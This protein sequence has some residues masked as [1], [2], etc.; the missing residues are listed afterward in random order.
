MRSES[1][2]RVA[3]TYKEN[4]LAGPPW[5]F[6]QAGV[7]I[8]GLVS[9]HLLYIVVFAVLAIPTALFV[10]WA[11]RLVSERSRLSVIPVVAVVAVVLVA[12]VG[13]TTIRRTYG[14]R[15]LRSLAGSDSR[16]ARAAEDVLTSEAVESVVLIDPETVFPTGSLYR[17][18]ALS[19]AQ[20]ADVQSFIREALPEDLVLDFAARDAVTVGGGTSIGGVFVLAMS[21]RVAQDPE[22]M[23][24]LVSRAA[25]FRIERSLGE[26]PLLGRRTFEF[27]IGE[28]TDNVPA[29]VWWRR[30]TNLVYIVVGLTHT[31]CR[32]I[33][34][35]IMEAEAR[36]G[37]VRVNLDEAFEDTAAYRF[38]R[39]PKTLEESFTKG[40]ERQTADFFEGLSAWFVRS[41]GSAFAPP[42][43][44]VIA[45][46]LIPDRAATPGFVPALAKE[47]GRQSHTSLQRVTIEGRITYQFSL[48]KIDFS[49]FAAMWR[50]P[51][52]TLHVLVVTEK[53]SELE[54]VAA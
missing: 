33:A 6:G 53:A 22:F 11:V 28:H 31:G 48:D 9:E 52:T 26:R 36:S 49:G 21:R 44:A 50:R 42:V 30:G 3:K 1:A 29:V 39:V 7:S 38:E 16:P 14:V 23:E 10:M 19:G 13:S 25:R 18:E 24:D 17:Y 2:V 37:A 15:P 5:L 4:K 32:E 20:S 43:G 47:L 27:M 8:P 34:R 54:K 12:A 40:F 41:R 35:P 45:F 46:G 51:G